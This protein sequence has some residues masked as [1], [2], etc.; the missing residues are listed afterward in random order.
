MVCS[1]VNEFTPKRYCFEEYREDFEHV[2]ATQLEDVIERNDIL[3]FFYQR[4]RFSKSCWQ[5]G[6]ENQSN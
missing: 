1:G 2:I 3:V 4:D 5:P 6:L